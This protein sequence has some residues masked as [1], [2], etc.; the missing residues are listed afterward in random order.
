MGLN[1]FLS[2]Y[3]IKK[4]LFVILNIFFNSSNQQLFIFI[5]F[6]HFPLYVFSIFLKKKKKNFNK[7]TK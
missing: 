4:S 5:N 2:I 6:T 1:H 7:N 3:T